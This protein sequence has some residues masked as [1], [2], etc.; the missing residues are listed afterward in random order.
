MKEDKNIL[1]ILLWQVS[2]TLCYDNVGTREV[3]VV[4]RRG[5]ARSSFV[6]LHAVSRVVVRHGLSV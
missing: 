3:V 6:L 1:E 2:A 5:A 4:Q